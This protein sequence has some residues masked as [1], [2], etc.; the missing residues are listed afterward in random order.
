MELELIV[1]RPPS[2]LDTSASQHTRK[3]REPCPPLPGR[4][5]D[6]GYAEFGEGLGQ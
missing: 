5:L 2:A 3:E 6:P 1:S 4:E